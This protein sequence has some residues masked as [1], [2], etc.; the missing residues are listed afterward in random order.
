MSD[1]PQPG[2]QLEQQSAPQASSIEGLERPATVFLSYA[3]EDTEIVIDLQMRLNMRGVFCLRDKNFLLSGSDFER[4]IEHAI[5]H[6]ADAIVLYLTPHC[7]TSDFIWKVEIASALRRRERDPHF[8]IM[9]ILHGVTLTEIQQC[10]FNYGLKK[11]DLSRF[12]AISIN[13]DEISSSSEEAQHMKRNDVA[14][15]LLQAAL[16]LRLRRIKAD[17]NY[18]PWI[19][20]KTFG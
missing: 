12:H 9:P 4:E 15:R 1:V 19:C 18:E 17:R 5:Q 7:L 10:G 13:Y 14:R 20:L 11:N 3:H 16:T 8:H 6:E 2:E